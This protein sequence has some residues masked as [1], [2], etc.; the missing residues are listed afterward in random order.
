[1]PRVFTQARAVNSFLSFFISGISS[2]QT[3]EAKITGKVLRS[4]FEAVRISKPGRR[5]PERHPNDSQD[6][7]SHHDRTS[8]R[9]ADRHDG[10]HLPR[11]LRRGRTGCRGARQRRLFSLHFRRLRLRRRGAGAD[12][13]CERRPPDGGSRPHLPPKRRLSLRARQPP[14][15]RFASLCPPGHGCHDPERRGRP[16]GGRLCFLASLRPSGRLPL[17][18]NARLLHRHPPHA[19]PHMEFG[20]D[21]RGELHLE[22]SAHFRCRPHPRARHQRR[23]DRLGRERNR[24][25]SLPGPGGRPERRCGA[26]FALSGPRMGRDASGRALSSRRLADGS[27]NDRFRHVALLFRRGRARQRPRAR[28]FKRRAASSAPSSSSS[29][30][31]SEPPAA[32]FRRIFME[33]RTS[34]RSTASSCGGSGSP[35]PP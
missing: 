8:P 25:P 7:R 34:A 6:G 11:P 17:R 22:R 33:R 5:H 9:A 20:R 10:R 3:R 26:V 16:R 18:G 30:T 19:R 2:N 1:M 35:T 32:P 28:D 29:C 14:C 31:L 12:G 15:P 27:G 24:R 23:G 21:G 4:S 13:S